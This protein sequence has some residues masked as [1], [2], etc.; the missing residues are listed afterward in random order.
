MKSPCVGLFTA[1][2]CLQG[3]KSPVGTANQAWLSVDLLQ[4]MCHFTVDAAKRPT[5]LA[6]LEHPIKFC[7][8]VRGA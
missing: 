4:I 8:E 5:V 6:M 1:L 2:F 3:G 7:P